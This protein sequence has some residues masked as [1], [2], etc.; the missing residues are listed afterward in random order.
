ERLRFQ[1][2]MPE[3][4]SETVLADVPFTDIGVAIQARIQSAFGIVRM[5]DLH[6]IELEHPLD[7]FQG[8]LQSGSLR[9]V[10]SRCQQMARVEAI[11]ERQIRRPRGQIPYCAQF[12]KPASDLA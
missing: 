10:M 5:N 11:S 3:N 4:A 8:L 2:G 6:Q 7:L 9:D 12:L 1:R